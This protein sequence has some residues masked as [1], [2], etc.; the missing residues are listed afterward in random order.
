MPLPYSKQVNNGSVED[1]LA[2]QTDR[3][4]QKLNN[5]LWLN[6]KWNQM[7]WI[8]VANVFCFGHTFLQNLKNV[9]TVS[10][11][12]TNTAYENSYCLSYSS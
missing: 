2:V 6:T 11:L 3:K 8:I 12:S 5:I 9:S 1:V 7:W 4:T 10:R